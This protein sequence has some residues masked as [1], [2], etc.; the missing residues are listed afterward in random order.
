MAESADETPRQAAFKLMAA[1]I[2]F[3]LSSEPPERRNVQAF[4]KDW[5]LLLHVAEKNDLTV[6][7][8]VAEETLERC[9]CSSFDLGAEHR[10]ALQASRSF[11][12]K[13]MRAERQL[14]TGPTR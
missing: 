3:D 5:Q 1:V 2:N 4:D 7:S 12:Q 9:S 11:P 6:P 10:D 14:V 8:T 13:L